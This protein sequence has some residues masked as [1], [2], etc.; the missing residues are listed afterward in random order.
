MLNAGR[1][2]TTVLQALE[3]SEGTYLRWRNQYWNNSLCNSFGWRRPLPVGSC[4][5]FVQRYLTE[6]C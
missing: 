1:D 5:G 3:I 2:L 6:S 4:T